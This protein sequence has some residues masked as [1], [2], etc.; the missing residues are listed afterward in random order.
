V[1]AVG[2]HT[3]ATQGRH[4]VTRDMSEK[5][6]LVVTPSSFK[7][8]DRVKVTVLA[9]DEDVALSGHVARVDENPVNSPE[10]WRWRVGIALD[11]PLPSG[12]IDHGVAIRNRFRAA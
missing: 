2:I 9:G 1:L 6:L 12:F 10:L 7:M 3:E 5:G 8:G 11:E 4:G